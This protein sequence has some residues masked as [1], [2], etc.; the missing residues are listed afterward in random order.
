MLQKESARLIGELQK[1]I[2]KRAVVNNTRIR[3]WEKYK[4]LTSALIDARD[5]ITDSENGL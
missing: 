1:A 5:A 3:D 4:K 2:D